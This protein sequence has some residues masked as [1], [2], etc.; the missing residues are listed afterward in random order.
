MAKI[1]VIG[2]TKDG[3]GKSRVAQQVAGA[4]VLKKQKK[5]HLTDIDGQTADFCRFYWD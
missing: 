5:C 2:G 3:S 4:L 1:I